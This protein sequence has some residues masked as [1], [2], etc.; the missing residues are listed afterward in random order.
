M[1]NSLQNALL[2]LIY[3]L[4][5][6]RA[7]LRINRPPTTAYWEQI[8]PILQWSQRPASRLQGIKHTSSLLC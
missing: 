5:S 3:T 6:A 2:R 4:R 7:E 8:S 1:T